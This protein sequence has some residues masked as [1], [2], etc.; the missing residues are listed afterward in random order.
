MECPQCKSTN[1]TSTGFGT[2]VWKCMQVNCGQ[3]FDR[4]GAFKRTT[5]VRVNGAKG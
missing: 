4:D 2:R 5:P 3:T 1:V